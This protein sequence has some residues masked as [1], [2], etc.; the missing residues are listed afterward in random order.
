MC[1]KWTK[2]LLV[3]VIAVVLLGGVSA[4]ALAAGGTDGSGSWKQDLEDAIAANSNAGTGDEPS[5][6]EGEAIAC[7]RSSTLTAQSSDLLSGAQTLMTLDGQ[8]RSAELVTAGTDETQ[9]LVLVHSDT[10][11]TED[12]VSQLSA[13]P[14][15]EFAEPNTIYSLASTQKKDLTSRQ[16]AYNTTYGTQIQD[17]NTYSASGSPTPRV[18]TSGVVVALLDSGVDY[19]HEDLNGIMWNQG[20][21]YP[22][23]T[24]LGGG[25]YGYTAVAANSAG[26]AYSTDDPM[27]DNNHG[28]HCAGII[29]GQWNGYGVSG[30]TSGAK[31]MAVK[32]ANDLGQIPTSD[33]LKGYNYINAA[34]DAGVNVKVIN[35][36]WTGLS[37]GRSVSRAI[38]QLGQKGVVSVL[39]S[40]NA[41]LDCDVQD[42]TVSTLKDN[43][44]AVVVDATDKD[45]NLAS[46]S[47]YGAA[48]T[49]VAAPGV[50]IYSTIIT[51]KGI[52]DPRLAD[53]ADILDDYERTA[54]NPAG[55]ALTY[56]STK[57]D[58]GTDAS[59][60]SIASGGGC[61]AG[62]NGLKIE[63]GTSTSGG[64]NVTG[65]LSAYKDKKKLAFLI[66]MTSDNEAIKGAD[67]ISEVRTTDGK[68]KTVGLLFGVYNAWTTQF[69]TLPDDTDYQNFDLEII[70]V[71][72][73][74]GE[75]QLPGLVTVIDKLAL[76]NETFPYNYLSG[77][78]MAAPAVTGEVAMLA[79]AYAGEGADKI[80]ARV[81]GS[82]TSLD[83][84]TGK[85]V[86][87]GLVS[88]TKALAGDT[89]PVVNS[90]AAP[91]SGS[92][93]I[94][95]YFFGSTQGSVTID[96]T[97]AAVTSWSDTAVTVTLPEGFTAGQK[98]IEV[99][100]AAGRAGH[101][102]LEVGSAANL[103]SRIAMPKD[104]TAAQGLLDSIGI[105]MTGLN[106]HL[107]Y[108]SYDAS[109]HM[110]L[111]RYTEGQSENSGW[112][113]MASPDGLIL[114]SYSLCTWDGNLVI[115]AA[116]SSSKGYGLG[117]YNPATNTWRMV[118]CDAL[119]GLGNQTV[120]N[121]GGKLYL[122]GGVK[123]Q[124]ISLVANTAIYTVD[125]KTGS[126]IKVG[127]LNTARISPAAAYTAD[128]QIYVAAGT[129]S[130]TKLVDG[131]ERITPTADGVTVETVKSAVLPQNLLASQG[132]K[133]STATVDGG[134]ILTGLVQ[135]D[136]GGTVPADTYRLDFAGDSGFVSTGKIVSTSKV[137]SP[138][139]TAYRGT[140]YTLGQTANA[141]GIWVFAKDDTVSTLTQP[142]EEVT[143]SVTYQVH[144]RNYGWNQGFKSDGDTAG[145]TGQALRM[146]A[147]QAKIT[148]QSGSAVD[149]LGITYQV[150]SQN[151]GWSQG[152][153]SDGDTAGTTGQSL[154]AEAVRMML[155]GYKAPD[156][157]VTYRVHVQNLGWTQWVKNGEVAGTTGRGL[158]IEA[159]QVQIVKK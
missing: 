59:T 86:S 62:T 135:A 6:V 13:L 12:L 4:V 17:W 130:D 157:D 103:Y 153:K 30:A 49:D 25:T 110:Q 85:C 138:V 36:S 152:Y 27:D 22:A 24:N 38:T 96:G 93:T 55:S 11:G 122:I 151:L 28:T 7:V 80:A 58:D 70:T 65:D 47:N 51:S 29:A 52:L 158:R 115:S 109:Y 75:V 156:Y 26:T 42:A 150:H 111:W 131:L 97:A 104:S 140:W 87:G 144:G 34:V 113:R 121:S 95:G 5:Y 155:T 39:A 37:A 134:M 68:M 116:D 60:L 142:G 45:G 31:I 143:P 123:Q 137:L 54:V 126:A 127:D 21:N 106:G 129:S 105:G 69:I 125:P 57:N 119:K 8:A 124:G 88:V 48:T 77:T 112:T 149:G 18:D 89:V 56:T 2:R 10:L 74:G 100:S 81:I 128:G 83:S 15:V 79:K 23:L 43:P 76:T 90:V 66:K 148:D 1:R 154:R 14:G 3:L 33:I 72:T 117:I 78:S 114:N 53:A 107:Y 136:A 61:D 19:D 63:N 91:E 50:D 16:W 132:L 82:V 35:N 71:G 159:I 146:E 101:Q 40:G 64:V 133:Y 98:T 84:L 9:N 141:D 44:Y 92:L 147:L 139:S 73:D 120:V 108:L 102:S 118:T 145:T 99:T 94:S 32:A 67:A 20:K 46:F 41:K